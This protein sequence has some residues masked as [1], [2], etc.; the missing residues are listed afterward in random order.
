MLD[1]DANMSTPIGSRL[2]TLVESTSGL[3]LGDSVNLAIFVLTIISLVISFA[4]IWVAEETLAD[5]RQSG[6]EQTEA[7]QQQT[8]AL[9]VQISA[10]NSAKDSLNSLL[11]EIEK[12]KELLDSVQKST[13]GSLKV[14]KAENGRQLAQIKLNPEAVWVALQCFN[15]EKSGEEFTIGFH[16]ESARVETSATGITKV[17]WPRVEM[18]V[19]TK[20]VVDLICDSQVSNNSMTPILKA[21]F[22][23]TVRGTDDSGEKNETI[24]AINRIGNPDDPTPDQRKLDEIFLLQDGE[25]PPLSVSRVPR[26]FTFAVTVPPNQSDSYLSFSYDLEAS[27]LHKHERYTVR[28]KRTDPSDGR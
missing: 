3:N 8:A 4:G 15:I 26:I 19:S 13:E 17:F 25:V 10:L 6:K 27:N 18:S 16:N 11:G 1:S 5:A 28:I 23:W 21:T 22:S 14:L 20:E 2:K 12:Q 7:L 24:F 9:S